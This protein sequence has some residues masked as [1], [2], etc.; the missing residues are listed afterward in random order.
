[1]EH[2]F[3]LHGV[4][5]ELAKILYVFLYL[6]PERWQWL[7]WCKNSCQGYI[8][9]T[10]FVSYLYDLFETDTHYLGHLTKLKQSG[11]VKYFIT[12]FDHLAFRTEG[13]SDAFFRELFIN[14]LKDEI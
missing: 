8:A 7:K 6:Y 11:T 3:S 12:S 10:Q 13:M 5:D 4:T 2:Y 14:V 9:S 1:M